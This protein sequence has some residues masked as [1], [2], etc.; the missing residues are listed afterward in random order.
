MRKLVALSVLLLW[1]VGIGCEQ[2]SG[3][4]ISKPD[5]GNSLMQDLHLKYDLDQYRHK[6]EHGLVKR[7]LGRLLEALR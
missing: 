5:V 2:N 4:T 3:S 7:E 1:F 6:E